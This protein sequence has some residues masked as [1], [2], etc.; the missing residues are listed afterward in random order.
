MS[1]HRYAAGALR[2]DFLRAGSGL[3]LTALPLA[4]VPAGSVG[5]W[6]LALLAALFIAFAWRTLRRQQTRI[7]VDDDAV[8]ILAPRQARLA[9]RDL[10]Q[11]KLSYYSTKMDRAGGWM[12]LQLKPDQTAGGDGVA[13]AIVIDSTLDDFLDIARRV[14]DV[15]E[16]RRLPLS[17]ST[18]ANF[19][20]IGIT[21]TPPDPL[22]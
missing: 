10:G 1:E 17:A 19:A 4:L 14:A 7:A 5:F 20:A 22:A 11:V 21:V 9:W 2:A 15:A 8:S 12:Q 18:V 16:A 13:R 6:I 3:A